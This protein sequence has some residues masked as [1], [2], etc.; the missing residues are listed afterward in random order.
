MVIGSFFPPPLRI[1]PLYLVNPPPPLPYWHLM[2]HHFQCSLDGI[3]DIV[4]LMLK[5]FTHSILAVVQLHFTDE[6]V[7]FNLLISLVQG[8]ISVYYCSS[9]PL[10]TCLS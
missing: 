3:F 10:K 8:W 2:A 4:S 7:S 6:K 5:P 9:V 1:A